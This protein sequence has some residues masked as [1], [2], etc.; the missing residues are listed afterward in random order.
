MKFLI[1]LY[2]I[3]NILIFIP[4]S[5]QAQETNLLATD[6]LHGLRRIMVRE[7]SLHPKDTS[8]NLYLGYSYEVL[9]GKDG[10]VS[11]SYTHST[12]VRVSRRQR[13]VEEKLKE[14][15]TNENITLH[16]DHIIL[17]PVMHIWKDKRDRID[18]LAEVMEGLIGEGKEYPNNMKIRIEKP[19]VTLLYE[20]R[21]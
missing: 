20:G 12:P 18:N 17:F 16:E 10:S 13:I 19:I 21:Y 2:L 5:L 8:D 6:I 11:I 3:L 1:L 7:A 14:F 15:M 9:F 4:N